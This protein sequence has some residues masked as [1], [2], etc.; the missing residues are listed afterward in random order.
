MIPGTPGI[1][2]VAPA[3][4]VR[5]RTNPNDKVARAPGETRRAS[6]CRNRNWARF[7]IPRP[8]SADRFVLY[9][10][11]IPDLIVLLVTCLLP[12]LIFPAWSLP[13]LAMPIYG[14]LVILFGLQ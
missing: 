10:L 3:P 1:P 5:D 7:L 8:Q 11:A 2:F 4:T 13:Q 14:V 6:H 12:S 9:Q